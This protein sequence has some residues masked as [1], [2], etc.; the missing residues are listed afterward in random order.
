MI[1]S[2][3]CL[4]KELNK[5]REVKLMGNSTTWWIY[6]SDA[7]QQTRRRRKGAAAITLSV[8]LITIPDSS[9]PLLRGHQPIWEFVS[10]GPGCKE[11]LRFDVVTTLGFPN[12]VVCLDLL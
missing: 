11:A 4:V 10:D 6:T 5:Q 9:L 7:F 2:F 1:V 8:H 12:T 3:C